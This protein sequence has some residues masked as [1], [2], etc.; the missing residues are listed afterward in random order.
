MGFDR[1]SFDFVRGGWNYKECIKDFLMKKIILIAMMILIFPSYGHAALDQLSLLQLRP[2]YAVAPGGG[3]YSLPGL[4]KAVKAGIPALK[5]AQ[6][7]L[8]PAVT[9]AVIG[10]MAM[11]GGIGAVATFGPQLISYLYDL[12]FEYINGE[13]KRKVVSNTTSYDI[14][15]SVS[16]AQKNVND[17]R[18][19]GGNNITMEVNY[20]SRADALGAATANCG[21]GGCNGPWGWGDS[22]STI[23]CIAAKPA[24]QS[25]WSLFYW[26][27]NAA[28]MV[29]HTGSTTTYE[30]VAQWALD[31]DIAADISTNDEQAQKMVAGAISQFNTWKEEPNSFTEEHKEDMAAIENKIL[32]GVSVEVKAKLEQAVATTDAYDIYAEKAASLTPEKTSVTAPPYTGGAALTMGAAA[33]PEVGDFAGLFSNFLS[34][35]QGTPLFSLPGLLSASVPSGGSCSMT[36]NMSAR[37]GGVHTVSICNWDTGLSYLKAVLLCIASIFA[38]GIVAKGGGA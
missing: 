17:C 25:G 23:G 3:A 8:T 31:A 5:W 18:A 13:L 27:V 1:R 33:V 35:M 7:G 15:Y 12:G 29:P 20:G 22:Y 36:V 38:V 10:R 2:A 30:P 19:C 14:V 16:Q 26:P 34:T 24:G 28:A 9:G 21:G 4:V 11:M 32:E 37:F 6:L